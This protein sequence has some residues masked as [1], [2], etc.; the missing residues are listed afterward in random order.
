MLVSTELKGNIETIIHYHA[1]SFINVSH[2][3][4]IKIRRRVFIDIRTVYFWLLHSAYIEV[5]FSKLL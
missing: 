4:I 1:V 2:C 5:V 3:N